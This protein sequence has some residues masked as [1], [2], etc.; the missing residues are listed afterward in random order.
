MAGARSDLCCILVSGVVVVLCR[1][2]GCSKCFVGSKKGLDG[3]NRK[4][5]A[6][7]QVFYNRARSSCNL[8]EMVKPRLAGGF[9]TAELVDDDAD[10]SI[11]ELDAGRCKWTAQ[12]WTSEPS[13]RLLPSAGK[14]A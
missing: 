13:A 3:K 1:V 2:C 9:G 7:R 6:Q 4:I 12:G 11:L 10:A 14:S 5:R 8:L